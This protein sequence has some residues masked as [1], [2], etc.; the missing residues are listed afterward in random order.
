[1]QNQTLDQPSEYSQFKVAMDSWIKKFNKDISL[2][3]QYPS[4]IEEN[5]ENIEHNYELTKELMKDVDSLKQEIK[6]LRMV[7]IAMLQKKIQ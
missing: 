2:F 3:R 7:Q 1:M 5:A 6:M 4:L